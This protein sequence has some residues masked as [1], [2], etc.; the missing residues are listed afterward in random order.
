M[1]NSGTNPMWAVAR[2]EWGAY[3]NS[4]VAYIFIIIF[5]ALAGFFTFSVSRFYEAGQADLRPF[6][7]WHP[8]L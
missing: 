2:R 1:S 6:F 3:F 4:P 8:W 7:F 5:L